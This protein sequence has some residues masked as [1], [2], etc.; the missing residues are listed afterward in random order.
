MTEDARQIAIPVNAHRVEMPLT[1]LAEG[2]LATRMEIPRPFYVRLRDKTPDVLAMLV[3]QLFAKAPMNAMV[4]TLDGRVRAI[5]S[6][7]YRPLDNAD[8]A[9]AVLPVIQQRGAEVQSCEITETRLYIKVTLPDLTAELPV[10]QGLKMGVG[11]NFFVRKITAGL[12]IS[13]SE[14]GCGSIAIDPGIF[15]RQCTNY[16]RFEDS[17]YRR[18]H[19]GGK[20]DAGEDG[21]SEFF[22]ERPSSSVTRRSGR[23]SGTWRSPRWMAACSRRSSSS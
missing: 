20:K 13:N 17:S 16:A 23:R 9:E 3:N 12:T 4:R 7:R 11:H 19:I 21:I 2:Q 18:V 15:E 6:D 22:S 14:V 8:L 10:P 1:D 5:M